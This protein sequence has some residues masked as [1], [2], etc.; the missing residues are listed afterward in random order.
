[1]SEGGWI[2]SFRPQTMPGLRLFC[3]PYAGRGASVYSSWTKSLPEEVEVCAVQL[4]GREN[5]LREPLFT[6]FPDLI[7][8]LVS[9]LQPW[10]DRPFAFFGH[11]LGALISFELASELHRQGWR[12]PLQLFVSA[13]RAPHLPEPHGPIADLPGKAFIEAVRHRYEGIPDAVLES[14]DLMEIMIPVLRADFEL[15]EK[16]E[17]VKKESLSCPIMVL[18]G[19]QDF[20]IGDEELEAWRMHTRNLCNLKFFA[21]NHFFLNSSEGEVLKFM[22]KE[23]SSLLVELAG[24]CS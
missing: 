5:R 22:S 1:M 21:G 16:Y 8:T 20:E 14:E 19:L 3:F 18:G 17:F 7:T 10:M 4:P 2:F 11:S 15:L 24:R 9:A 23:L 12:G 6:H 13:R